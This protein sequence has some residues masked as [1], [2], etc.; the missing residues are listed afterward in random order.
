MY[1]S[2]AVFFLSVSILQPLTLSTLLKAVPSDV[3][4]NVMRI[5]TVH[6]FG[7][8]KKSQKPEQGIGEDEGLIKEF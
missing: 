3:T 7:R 6:F 8:V 4:L 2:A 5:P 1:H